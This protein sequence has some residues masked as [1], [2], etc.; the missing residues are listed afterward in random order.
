MI[1]Y[2]STNEHEQG[3]SVF[4]YKGVSGCPGP[5]WLNNFMKKQNLSLKNATKLLFFQQS[6]FQGP[7]GVVFLTFHNIFLW[8]VVSACKTTL[9]KTTIENT[10]KF[11]LL[12][13]V[14]IQISIQMMINCSGWLNQ[15]KKACP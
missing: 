8:H 15:T 6:I 11:I 7:L 10:I 3:K 13:H 4:H 5:D 12:C 9:K 1:N 14:S 2:V